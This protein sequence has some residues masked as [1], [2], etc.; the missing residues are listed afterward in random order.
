MKI[1][2][3][4]G[5]SVGSPDALRSLSRIVQRERGDGTPL[6]VVCSAMGGV[7]NSLLR[8]GADA[9]AGRDVSDEV[10]GIEHH[11]LSALHE[12]ATGPHA[13]QAEQRIR[14]HI[15]MMGDWLGG[16][17]ALGE[18]TPAVRDRLTSFGELMSCEIVTALL[19][20]AGLD[21]WLADSREYIV[22]AS[23][24]SGPALYQKEPTRERLQ[25]QF[26][27]PDGR[28]PVM[29]GFIASDIAS[30]RTTTLGRGGSD[31]TAAILG[32]LLEADEVQI[33]TDV[34]GFMTADPRLVPRAFSQPSLSYDEAMELSYFGAKVIY[35]PSLTP[36]ISGGIPIRVLNTFNADH[37]GTLI[38]HSAGE[39]E[40]GVKGISSIRDVAVITVEGSGMIG[41]KGFSGRLFG[42]LADA[43]VNV[44]LITQASSEHSISFAV[45]PD[46]ADRAAEAIRAEFELER[47]RNRIKDPQV[48]REVSIMAVVGEN[49]K[50]TRGFSGRVFTALGRNGINVIAIAQ[51]SSELNISV[52]IRTQDLPRGLNA[53]HDAL[54]FPQE[55]HLHLYCAGVGTVGREFLEQ[56]RAAAETVAREQQLH[57][58]VM[59]IANSRRMLLAGESERGDGSGRGLDLANWPAALD[60]DGAPA[61]LD[62]FA[63]AIPA[64]C[65][66]NS[67][68]VDN[69]SSERV[70]AAYPAL[71]GKGVSVVTC[72]KIGNSGTMADYRALRDLARRNHA[73]FL[74]ETNVGAG[75]PVIRTI[76]NFRLTGD[77][78]HRIEAIVSGT[79]AYLFNHYRPGTTFAEIVRSAQENGFTEPDPRDDLNGL[80][81]RRKMLILAREIGAEAEIEQ[82]EMDSILPQD[83]LEAP[84]IEAFYERL[85]AA[86]A[87]F[88]ALRDRAAEQG[89]VL[90][91]IGI[92]EPGMSGSGDPGAAASNSSSS[93]SANA[94][95]AP[96]AASTSTSARMAVE[97]KAVGPEHPFYTLSGSENIVAVTTDRYLESPLVIRGPGAG[98]SV[99]AAG[100]FADLMRVKAR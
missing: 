80:D 70:V 59:G 3:F 33:W 44:V 71:L 79:I 75:L 87:H 11:H 72:N 17:R 57:L 84:S 51:G 88:A 31:L 86:E 1:L 45:V 77:R 60:G 95:T 14:E 47:M 25:A 20:E 32:G 62:A 5:T 2:K 34:D 15:A 66:P 19:R 82:V 56:I 37:P 69:T 65:L 89:K 41:L 13:Q 76:E 4:G 10:R 9:T 61:D 30:G 92:C 97:L 49:M 42:V 100:V 52:V 6:I 58:H 24:G 39:S 81:F 50:H 93:N 85:E 68:F 53:V 27:Q 64:A 22:T 54:F 38:H 8:F 67:V 94:A 91:C 48:T 29:T 63:Q 36:A 96:S 7:T 73:D 35:P 18:C 98:A 23:N 74:Y 26:G 99:T 83:C 46:E 40:T 21:A 28:V 12:L 90:R 43:D 78:V 55:R 16:I